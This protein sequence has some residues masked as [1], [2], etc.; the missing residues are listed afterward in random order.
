MVS[1]DISFDEALFMLSSY[2][3]GRTGYTSLR[4]ELKTKVDLPAHYRL[5]Q[6]KNSI[7]PEIVDLTDPLSG[8]S[9]RVKDSVQLHFQRLI[10]QLGLE[11]GKYTMKVKEGLDGSGRH[12]VYD[13]KGN[14]QTHNMIMWM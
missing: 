7:M 12:S 6:H 8:V 4:Q 9:L 5:M 10:M 3:H 13:Q 2:K 11:P 14:V 1:R